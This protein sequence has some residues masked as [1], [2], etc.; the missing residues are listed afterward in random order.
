METELYTNTPTPQGVGI[1]YLSERFLRSTAKWGRFLAISGFV[2]IGLIILA[3]LFSGII[4]TAIMGYKDPMF[5]LGG[6]SSITFS[7]VALIYLIPIIFLYRFSSKMQDGLNTKDE[8]L[9][10]ESFKNLRAMFK[11]AGIFTIIMIALYL[12]S[13]VFVTIGLSQLGI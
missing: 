2:I 4:Y 6:G 13:I 1:N 12:L 7:F 11:F 10:A 8:G 9:V 3:G 5:V